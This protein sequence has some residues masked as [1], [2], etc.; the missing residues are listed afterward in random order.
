MSIHFAPAI[1]A[2]HPLACKP[3]ARVMA[4]RAAERVA[5]D[6]PRHGANQLLEAALHH[7]A[8]HGLGAARAALEQAET[9]RQAGDTHGYDRWMGIARQLDRRMVAEAEGKAVGR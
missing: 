6:G 5:N 3:V 1:R 2:D 7:F 4:L 9:A 8:A